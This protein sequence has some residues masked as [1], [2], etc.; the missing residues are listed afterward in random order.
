MRKVGLF[1]K[2]ARTIRQPDMDFI[3]SV[4]PKPIKSFA[5]AS[6]LKLLNRKRKLAKFPYSIN[7]ELTNR[8]NLK[9]KMC[10]HSTIKNLGLKDMEFDLFKN[11]IDSA[12]E[13]RNSRAAISPVGLGEPLIY[14]KFMNAI[15]YIKERCP[16]IPIFLD[17]NATLL[18]ADKSEMLCNML[19]EKDRIMFSINA[20][21]N[22]KYREL[23]GIDAFELVLSNINSFLLI[24]K[25][26]GN[27]PKLFFQLLDSIDNAS[28]VDEF[29]A[30]WQSRM[31]REDKFNIAPLL[32]WGGQ[33][34]TDQLLIS[35][36][37][38]RYPCISL[39][40]MVA[41]DSEGNAYPC[42]EALSTRKNSELMLGNVK[43][44]SLSELYSG[45]KINKFRKKHLAGCWHSISEC[46]RCD[47]WSATR[48][49]WFR[50]GKTFY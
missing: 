42:C 38:N 30:H 35:K 45:G 40:T 50:F 33:I 9:C 34:E 20:W 21:T 22:E 37:P 36:K 3:K 19:D 29:R 10:P 1:I 23:M 14:P 32:N 16:H 2:C 11:I 28:E 25:K 27:G 17:T 12:A 31:N 4:I 41:I 6:F 18:R 13:I 15:Q 8:C 48:S 24:R 46:S 26:I 47:F 5:H 39:W 7:I 44:C 49:V 43:D